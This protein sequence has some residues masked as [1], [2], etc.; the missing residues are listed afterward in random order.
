MTILLDVFSHRV[1]I[2]AFYQIYNLIMDFIKNH[3]AFIAAGTVLTA[4]IGIL[5]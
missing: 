3:K 4:G 1:F 5:L 2:P